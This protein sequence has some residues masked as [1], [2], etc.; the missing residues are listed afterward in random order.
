[1]G[2]VTFEQAEQPSAPSSSAS[3]ASHA[4]A[5][6]APASAAPATAAAPSVATAPAA[7]EKPADQPPP[8]QSGELVPP[9]S[10]TSA[11]QANIETKPEAAQETPKPEHPA[12]E[13]AAPAAEMPQ[14]MT[15]AASMPAAQAKSPPA[16]AAG[17]GAPIVDARRDGDGLS[18]TFSFPTAPPAAL[19]RRAHTLWLVVHSTEAIESKP[20]AA[21]CGVS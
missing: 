13:A 9:A 12:T 10:E 17:N 15:L 20:N 1:M 14:K 18:L 7:P 21:Q 19:F 4:P 16:T 2:D 6:D 11:Q 8:G 5:S 3:D